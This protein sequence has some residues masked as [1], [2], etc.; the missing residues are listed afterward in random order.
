MVAKS[1]HARKDVAKIQ[2]LMK[3]LQTTGKSLP[4]NRINE[5]KHLDIMTSPYN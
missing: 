3:E 4:F 2:S 5:L 1:A